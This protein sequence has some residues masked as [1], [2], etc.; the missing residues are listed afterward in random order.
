MKK[1]IFF[2]S[3]L[4]LAGSLYA[5]VPARRSSGGSSKA[6]EDATSFAVKVNPASYFFGKLSFLGEYNFKNKKSLTFGLGIP[7][8]VTTRIPTDDEDRRYTLKTFSLMA[9]YRMYLGKSTMSGF[10]FEPYLHYIKNEISTRQTDDIKLENGGTEPADFLITSNHSGFGLGAQLGVQFLIGNRVTIDLFFLGPEA[11]LAKTTL[12]LKD[13]INNPNHNATWLLIDEQEA[14]NQIK[15]ELRK[16]P[17]M[18]K[19]L[20]DNTKVTVD[21]ANRVISAEYNGF[22]PGF[23]GG[24]TLG[25]R[26]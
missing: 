2:L 14:E 19:M 25:V 4:L 15:S 12:S 21:Q 9:G 11:N 1:T 7:M 26:F 20:A 16:V 3:A 13:Q 17:L 5:Q 24:L 6:G 23:R 10:Y 8:E 22:L 18:G